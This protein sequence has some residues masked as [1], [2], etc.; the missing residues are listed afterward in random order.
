MRFL[1]ERQRAILRDTEPMPDFD[2]SDFDDLAEAVYRRNSGLHFIKGI[3]GNM[4]NDG[5]L[6]L[7]APKTA[8][9]AADW[10]ARSIQ[11]HAAQKPL[12]PLAEKPQEN[13][14]E[15]RKRLARGD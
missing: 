14:I 10:E 3:P 1:T 5:K 6:G 11:M 4:E 9:S 13:T 7:I 12:S 8:K 2:D 15:I